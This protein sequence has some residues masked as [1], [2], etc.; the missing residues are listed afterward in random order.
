MGYGYKSLP[1][2]HAIDVGKVLN[3][4]LS[5]FVDQRFGGMGC[6]VVEKYVVLQGRVEAAGRAS[7]PPERVV[8]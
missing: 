5:R 4:I 1:T 8:H 2:L 7:R 6:L 3:V